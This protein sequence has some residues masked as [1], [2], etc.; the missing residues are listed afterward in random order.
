[1]NRR[2]IF[3]TSRWDDLSGTVRSCVAD[4]GLPDHPNFDPNELIF[5]QY[6]SGSKSIF[7][8]IPNTILHGVRARLARFFNIREFIFPT[9]PA[10]D[11]RETSP[12]T[13]A[14]AGGLDSPL[15]AVDQLVARPALH[16]RSDPHGFARG[17]N[18]DR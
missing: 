16:G 9:S 13:L 7:M 10:T 11:H 18:F 4:M 2:A 5:T 17:T 12:T 14:A 15:L 1:M 6:A 3:I 8:A